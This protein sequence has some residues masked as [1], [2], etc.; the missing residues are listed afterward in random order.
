MLISC[1][2]QKSEW[3]GTI[4]EV[5]GVT[6]V[7]NPKEPIYGEEVFNLE[8]ELCIGVAEG[9][10]EY[11]FSMINSIAVDDKENIYVL[12]MQPKIIRVFNSRGQFMHTIGKGGGQ[13]PGE[14]MLPSQLQITARNEIIVYDLRARALSYFSFK[15]SFLSKTLLSKMPFSLKSMLDSNGDFIGYFWYAEKDEPLPALMKYNSIQEKQFVIAKLDPYN[16]REPRRLPLQPSLHF[17]VFNN[18]I[19]WAN[20]MKYEIYITSPMGLLLKKIFKEDSPIEITE[21]DKKEIVPALYLKDTLSLEEESNFA[22][23]YDPINGISVDEENRIFIDTLEK[24]ND[25]K[26]YYH[27]VFDSEGRYIA[28]VGLPSW[29]TLGMIWKNDKLYTIID[30]NEKGFPVVKRYKVTWKIWPDP[31]HPEARNTWP[32]LPESE[33]TAEPEERLIEIDVMRQQY[34]LIFLLEDRIL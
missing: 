17:N 31:P 6:V 15:G 22:K 23:Y 20:S 18:N 9:Q 32:W 21:Q 16:T 11:M 3:Q 14:F 27:D 7:R 29:P 8:E 19:V 4:E 33:M 10:E 13:G 2:Q 28:R 1:G 5:D 30:A 25:R 26:Y 34:S 12:D 24:T